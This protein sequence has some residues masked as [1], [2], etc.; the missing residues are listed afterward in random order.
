M[1]IWSK[2]I[3][4]RQLIGKLGGWDA[5][6]LEGCI[7]TKG[8]VKPSMIPEETEMQIYLRAGDARDLHML[9]QRVAACIVAAAK[10]S[11]CEAHFEF[12]GRPYLSMIHNCLLAELFQ[13]HAEMLGI[14]FSTD[15][16]SVLT[17]TG[18]SDMGN[19]SHRVPSI[20]PT[21]SIDSPAIVK[22][23][24]FTQAAG[25]DSAHKRTLV[26]AKALAMSM[27]EVLEKPELMDDI[28]RE[29]EEAT[30]PRT[31]TNSRCPSSAGSCSS[32]TAIPMNGSEPML[33]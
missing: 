22:T 33:A 14:I 5:E 23:P 28:K 32:L 15:P 2:V 10:A 18:S 3:S 1:R 26:T 7:I 16:E 13:K 17:P 8:G 20:R 6:I 27:I 31:P 12:L 29:F 25:T 21:F 4:H 19:V 9:Q 11:G 24:A 30:A